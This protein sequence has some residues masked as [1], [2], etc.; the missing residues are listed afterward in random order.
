MCK[1]ESSQKAENRWQ[2]ID[3]SKAYRNI[4]AFKY[5]QLRVFSKFLN[6]YEQIIWC[7]GYHIVKTFIKNKPI[8]FNYKLR[9]LSSYEGFQFNFEV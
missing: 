3:S 5:G 1:F 2:S 7:F 8:Q 4:S 6:V 9:S